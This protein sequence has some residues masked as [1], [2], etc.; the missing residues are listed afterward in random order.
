MILILFYFILFDTAIA[1][2]E[3]YQHIHIGRT[4]HATDYPIFAQQ[5]CLHYLQQE[6]S[7]SSNT[8]LLA[9][10]QKVR[11]CLINAIEAEQVSCSEFW[12]KSIDHHEQC[13]K[14]AKFCD[15]SMQ[16]KFQLANMTGIVLTRFDIFVRTFFRIA[17]LCMNQ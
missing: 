15:L 16:D 1:N 4:C 13:F 10:N 3:T 14:H 5:R 11:S 9:F 2:C 8:R 17:N 7:L 12:E 6:T